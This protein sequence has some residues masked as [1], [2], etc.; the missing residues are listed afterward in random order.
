MDAPYC[1]DLIVHDYCKKP[2]QSKVASESK[3]IPEEDHT[4]IHNILIKYDFLFE[5]TLGNCKTKP[6]DIELKP[7]AKM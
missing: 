2:N 7:D 5:I 3:R 1:T 6:M 4:M